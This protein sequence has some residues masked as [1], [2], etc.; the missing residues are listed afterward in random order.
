MDRAW[1]TELAKEAAP[2]WLKEL[3]ARRLS[4]AAL[5]RIQHESMPQYL[6]GMP[7]FRTVRSLGSGAYNLASE[8]LTN[9]PGEFGRTSVHKLPLTDEGRLIHAYAPVLRESL[10]LQRQLPGLTAPIIDVTPRGLFQRMADAQVIPGWRPGFFRSAETSRAAYERLK[11]LA[12]AGYM[13]IRPGNIGPGGQVFD[14]F[15]T[16]PGAVPPVGPDLQA[17]AHSGQ[18]LEDVVRRFW[19]APPKV[20]EQ[21]RQRLGAM[22]VKSPQIQN[23]EELR[24]SNA[25]GFAALGGMS[26]HEQRAAALAALAGSFTHPQSGRGPEDLFR[27]DLSP[28]ILHAARGATSA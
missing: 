8:V 3:Q 5:T 9:Y 4:P 27:T 24:H 18:P 6:G 15:S 2:R 14:W 22:A 28:T 21:M 12:R 13:D 17:L 19:L 16:R 20:R 11:P 25:K 23:M 7:A 1:L 26:P 10:D